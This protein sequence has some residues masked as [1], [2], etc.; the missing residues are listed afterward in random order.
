MLVES[1]FPPYLSRRG[2]EGCH[3][4]KMNCDLWWESLLLMEVYSFGWTVWLR[5]PD[6]YTP[7]INSRP[8]LPDRIPPGRSGSLINRCLPVVSNG[9]GREGVGPRGGRQ[10]LPG[11]SAV[12][13]AQPP[14]PALRKSHRQLFSNTREGHLGAERASAQWSL[15]RVSH[16]PAGFK[17]R[18]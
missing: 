14:K 2:L 13:L 1:F 17:S 12:S 15:N 5:P 3:W 7:L 11:R 8:Q 4:R 9:G 18:A 16:L 6:C 10:I